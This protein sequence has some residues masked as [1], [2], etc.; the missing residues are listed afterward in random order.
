MKYSDLQ[1][2]PDSK[3]SDSKG[4]PQVPSR[5]NPQ[6]V[7]LMVGTKIKDGLS[8]DGQMQKVYSTF[9]PGTSQHASR[10]TVPNFW[11]VPRSRRMTMTKVKL[12]FSSA[13]WGIDLP[14]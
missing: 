12:S 11:K 10:K 1:R 14:K 5:T 3:G 9:I 8:G 2:V 7:K 13:A 6:M 4:R